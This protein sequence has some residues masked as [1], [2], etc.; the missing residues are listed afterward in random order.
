MAREETP[1]K[2]PGNAQSPSGRLGLSSDALKAQESP[3]DDEEGSRRMDPEL[4]VMGAM[5]RLLN[6]LDEPAK[7]RAVAWLASRYAAPLISLR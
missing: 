4:R 1:P 7:G 3:Q 6:E 2:A 5:L